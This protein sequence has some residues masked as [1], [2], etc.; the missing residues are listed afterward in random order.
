MA[1]ITNVWSTHF[2]RQWNR[3]RTNV[4]CSDRERRWTSPNTSR[5]I[6]PCAVRIAAS[7]AKPMT[8][9]F[10]PRTRSTIVTVVRFLFF[11]PRAPERISSRREMVASLCPPLSAQC[12][13]ESLIWLM[14]VALSVDYATENHVVSNLRNR[15]LLRFTS[16]VS[17]TEKKSRPLYIGVTFNMPTLYH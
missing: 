5:S 14:F 11:C 2:H 9:S 3:S 15:T 13:R 12:A 10:F 1:E 6:S 4:S 16:W 8:Y 7:I 17:C